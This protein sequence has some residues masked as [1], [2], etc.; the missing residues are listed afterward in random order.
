MDHAYPAFPLIP[1]FE[2]A[3]KG[4]EAVGQTFGVI[5]PV[6]ADHDVTRHIVGQTVLRA[7]ALR[8][9]HKGLHVDADGERPQRHRAGAAFDRA[10]HQE[11][12]IGLGPEHLKTAGHIGAGL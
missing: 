11:F 4:A 5:E 8:G 2:I 7:A 9:L 1:G 10:I 3:A 12:G 6:D